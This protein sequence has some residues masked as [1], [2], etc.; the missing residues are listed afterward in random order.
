MR[1]TVPAETVLPSA[2]VM[3]T[4]AADGFTYVPGSATSAYVSGS[5]EV[6]AAVASATF[7]DAPAPGSTLR[8]DFTADIDNSSGAVGTGD[9]PYVFDVFADF[10]YDGVTD[11]GG[12]TFYPAGAADAVSDTG[13]L[14]WSIAG[15][16]RSVT[17]AAS[18]AIDQPR[19]TLDKTERPVSGPYE[20]GETVG[21]RAVITNTGWATAYNLSWDDLLASHMSDPAVVAVTHSVLGDVL[22]SVTPDTSSDD[23]VAIDFNAVTLAPGETITVDWTAVVD[24]GTGAGLLLTDTADVDWESHPTSPARRVYNDGPDEAAWTADTDQATVQ[25]DFAVI[26]KSIEWGMT[27]RTIGETFDYTVSFSVPTSTTAYNVAI[28]D[29]VPDGLTVLNVTPSSPIG[30]V[31]VGP[32]IMGMTTIVWNVGDVSN[33]PLATLALDITVR[34]DQTFFGGGALDGLPA[35]IDGD[36]VSSVVNTA[37]IVW[38][39]ADTGGTTRTSTDSVTITVI[40]PHLLIDKSGDETDLA[41]GDAVRYTV[42]VDNDGVAR[43]RPGM[44]R[45]RS[46]RSVRRRDESDVRVGGDRRHSARPGRRLH[47]V[48]RSERGLHA[49]SR[50]AASA[51]SALEIVYDATLDGGVARGTTLAN[52]A[53]VA[54]TSRPG[55]A[56]GERTYGPI[57][58]MWTVT[59]LAPQLTCDKQTLGDTEVQRGETVTYSLTVGNTGDAAAYSVVVTDTLPA[60]SHTFRAASPGRFRGSVRSPT[61]PR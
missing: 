44:V 54:Y 55:P 4:I 13:A 10:V 58:D 45:H 20:G 32:E 37:A 14:W 16:P 60:G 1:M 6:A 35:P 33:P 49:R 48:V 21:Y 27:T 18:T 28:T 8:V 31:L 51:G 12:W 38:D 52:T 39:D 42:R 9:V 59:A 15:V 41:A 29:V 19:L 53:Q 2:Y 24:P 3:D 40:E 50:R 47:G 57:T 46:G 30:T 56:P 34:V 17:D 26:D 36:G 61:T 22:A 43:V 23:V 11:A 25:V 5:P 7:D